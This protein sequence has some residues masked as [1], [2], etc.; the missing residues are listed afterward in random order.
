MPSGRS[1][2]VVT[3][4]VLIAA[5][6]CAYRLEFEIN[7]GCAVPTQLVLVPMLFVLPLGTV[8]FV[9][10]GS[11]A[12]VCLIDVVRGFMHRERIAQVGSNAWHSIGPVIVLGVAGRS[13]GAF[14]VAALRARA[15]GAVRLR[16]RGSRPS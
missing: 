6:V 1:P 15:A 11:I 3:V 10:A 9:V 8:P 16:L 12:L 4:A 7:T 5:Y 14:P 2:S 13:A